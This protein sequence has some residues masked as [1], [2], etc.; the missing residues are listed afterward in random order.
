[1]FS[2]QFRN[3]KG[4]YERIK[5]PIELFICGK[6]ETGIRVLSLP[7]G[8]IEVIIFP[9]AMKVKDMEMEGLSSRLQM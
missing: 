3:R 2:H 7:M 8:E 9:G 4:S 6:G 5:G 1:M